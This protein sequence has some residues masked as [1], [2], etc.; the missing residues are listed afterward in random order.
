MTRPNQ[1]IPLSLAPKGGRMR[2]PDNDFVLE[3]L[4]TMIVVVILVKDLEILKL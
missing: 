3:K 4:R 1:G 2:D